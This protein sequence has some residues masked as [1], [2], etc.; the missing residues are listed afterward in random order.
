VKINIVLE[1]GEGGGG[2]INLLLSDGAINL[3]SQEKN[4]KFI[5]NL[6]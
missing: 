2:I 1:M 5:T 6:L 4:N 3:F